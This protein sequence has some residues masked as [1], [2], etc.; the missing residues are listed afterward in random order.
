MD[1][2]ETDLRDELARRVAVAP[3]L[4]RLA[5]EALRRGRRARRRRA[6]AT[7]V[8][9]ACAVAMTMS[10]GALVWPP[11]ER[12]GEIAAV[13][14][15]GPPRVALYVGGTG[16]VLDWPGGARR[17]RT[18]GESAVPVAQVPSGLLVVIGGGQPA[19]GL[20]G[21]DDDEEPRVVVDGLDGD[22]V[23][24]SDDGRRATVVTA[25]DGVRQLLEVE[26]PSGRVLRSVG[27]APP[28]FGTGEPVLPAAYSARA[29]LVNIGEGGQQRTRL[30]EGNDDAV[31]GGIEGVAATVGGAR[32]D[33]DDDRDALGGRSAFTVR[34]DRC[35]T[36]VHE[37]RNGG[38]KPWRLCEEAFAGFS[39]DGEAVLATDATGTALLVRAADGGDLQRTFD[40]PNGVRAQGWESSS[41]LLY[42]TVDGSRTV[43]V[44]CSTDSGACA[45]AAELPGTGLIPQPVRTTR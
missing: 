31:I 44:R 43:V 18:L 41:T 3:G 8:G 17:T 23:A 1:R 38:G 7:A 28:V 2:L 34:D 27:L 14:L 29:V 32:A 26:L 4:P 39:P 21:P 40:V 45:Q 15:E 6:A 5:D 16:E 33:F 13:P 20:L 22:G 37:L 36:E 12:Q 24:V 25:R 42:T 19:L 11:T 9:G 30:W 10:L 35:R